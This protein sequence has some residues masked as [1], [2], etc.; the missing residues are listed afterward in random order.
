MRHNV[1]ILAALCATCSPSVPEGRASI[2]SGNRNAPR[3]EPIGSPVRANEREIPFVRALLRADLDAVRALVTAEPALRDAP[4]VS[5][6]WRG[7]Q[8]DGRPLHFVAERDLHELAALLLELG[9][10]PRLTDGRGATPLHRVRSAHMV[11]RL[12]AAGADAR[13]MT[14][15]HGDESRAST[16][17]TA[18]GFSR[19]YADET[20]RALIAAG[21]R[22]Q[23]ADAVWL[24]WEREVGELLSAGPGR[25][26]HPDLLYR[27][28]RS[29][30]DGIVALLIRGGVDVNGA[31]TPSRVVNDIDPGS[32]LEVAVQ[33]GAHDVAVLL[34]A[35]GANGGGRERIVGIDGWETVRMARILPGQRGDLLDRALQDGAHALASALLARGFDATEAARLSDQGEGRL[36]RAAW[37]GDTEALTLLLAA[38]AEVDAEVHGARAL[39][40][41]AAGGHAG[42]YDLLQARGASPSLHAAA[43]L[44]RR[45]DVERLVHESK[46]FLDERD[47][48]CGRTPLAWAV[49]A[50]SAETVEALLTAGA[51]P[52]VEIVNCRPLT[53]PDL[54]TDTLV[55]PRAEYVQQRQSVLAL[56]IERGRFDLAR[57]LSAQLSATERARTSD[58]RAMIARSDRSAL[59]ALCVSHA[60]EARVLLDELL[61][62]R[63][64][65]PEAWPE[66]V[67]ALRALIGGSLPESEIRARLA[68][69]EAAGAFGSPRSG[70]AGTSA[71]V[72]TQGKSVLAVSNPSGVHPGVALRLRALGAPV[73]LATAVGHG[74]ADLVRELDVPGALPAKARQA[75]LWDATRSGR[76]EVLG[77]LLQRA[78]EL[79]ELDRQRVV[80]AAAW[81]SD[82]ALLQVLVDSGDL[83]WEDVTRDGKTLLHYGAE[84]ADLVRFLLARGM[85]PDVRG[86]ADETPLHGASKAC[87]LDAMRVLLAAG[88]AVDARNDRGD[89]PLLTLFQHGRYHRDVVAAAELLLAAGADPLAIG[90]RKPRA[91]EEASWNVDDAAVRSALRALFER[92]VPRE[93]PRGLVDELFPE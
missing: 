6:K 19:V 80:A 55:L 75:L 73:D 93:A 21:A 43:A 46:Q 49:H 65:A 11:E 82:R 59:E 58:G 27:A 25:A 26:I 2:A 53:R 88:A 63:P 42:A 66:L 18:R 16:L 14:A 34:L 71:L 70:V 45:A 81:T 60:D 89:T 8:L 44:G 7:T 41:A 61:E 29:G 68:S 28:A 90:Y 20:A 92:H 52:A 9:A 74:W 1:V 54:Y 84:S 47:G 3:G 10:D 57:R 31:C 91:I 30:D 87:A 85:D 32:A 17:T 62:A 39:L 67:P 56:A 78:T 37:R 15:A 76:A 5:L 72:D 51:D 38:G 64:L 13:A 69:F 22:L 77:L 40:A 36:H 23:L 86:S 83:E 79:D 33:A 50:G 35:A 12:V 24:G 48:R 4:L